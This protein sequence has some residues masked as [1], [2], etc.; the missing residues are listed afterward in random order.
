MP[1]SLT[2]LAIAALTA[3]GVENADT[4]VEAFITIGVALLALYGRYR[5]GGLTA[6]GIRKRD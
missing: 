6:F 5:A 4:V 2:Y 3:L 1:L